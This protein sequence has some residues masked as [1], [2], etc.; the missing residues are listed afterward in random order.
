MFNKVKAKDS[1]DAHEQQVEMIW[2]NQDRKRPRSTADRYLLRSLCRKSPPN[3]VNSNGASDRGHNGPDLGI[4]RVVLRAYECYYG[5]RPHPGSR[6]SGH[7]NWC[8]DDW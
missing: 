5:S 7:K 2:N 4:G 6:C 8:R 1:A 3:K